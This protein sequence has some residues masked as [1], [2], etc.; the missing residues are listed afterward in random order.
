MKPC[1][2]CSRPVRFPPQDKKLNMSAQRRERNRSREE[3]R[4]LRMQRTTPEQ[5]C[6]VAAAQIGQLQTSSVHKAK[7]SAKSWAVITSAQ[8]EQCNAEELLRCRREYWGIEAGHQRLDMTLDEDR[9]RVRTPRAMTVLGMFRRLTVSF[10]C[11]WTE[12]PQRRKQK[13]STRDFQ[14]HLAV[15]NS[16]RGFS[17]VTSRGPKAWK[18]G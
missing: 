7:A 9:S 18:D 5:T 12:H 14:R 13:K 15:E 4:Q 6:F 8:P 17:L 11:A 2:G 3:C 16:R 10:A 1:I